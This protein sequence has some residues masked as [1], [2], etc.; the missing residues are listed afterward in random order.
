M[1]ASAIACS[2]GA[3]VSVANVDKI[4]SVIV[5]SGEPASVLSSTC[6]CAAPE[7][8]AS[9]ASLLPPEQPDSMVTDI[10]AHKMILIN[11]FLI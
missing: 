10:A 11:L 7:S 5:S 1:Y 3:S 2:S 8:F 9:D 6:D 4:R